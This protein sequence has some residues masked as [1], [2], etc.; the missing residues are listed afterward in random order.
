MLG[1]PVP[2]HPHLSGFCKK[3]EMNV[4]N[5]SLFG[6]SCFIY[7]EPEILQALPLEEITFNFIQHQNCIAARR[8]KEALQYIV[9]P[10]EGAV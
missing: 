8:V 9:Q 3:I 6:A 2:S 5:I 4:Q 7:L 1:L 10:E